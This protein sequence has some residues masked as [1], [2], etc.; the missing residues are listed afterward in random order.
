MSN[1]DS[2]RK[3]LYAVTL[4]VEIVVAAEDEQ[5]AHFEALD[6]VAE[7]DSQGFHANARPL[8]GAKD[9]PHG[10][11]PDCIPYGDG[12]DTTI[13]EYLSAEAASG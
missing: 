2:K 1:G 5:H 6:A 3:Q 10:W 4:E 7:L 9:L 11:D 8:L 12:D 13:A